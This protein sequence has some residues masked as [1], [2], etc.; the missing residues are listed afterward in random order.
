MSPE[1]TLLITLATT[2]TILIGALLA[3]YKLVNPIWKK[4][5]LWTHTWE[6]FMQDWVGTPE[7]EGRGKV[8]GVMER[9]NRIDGQLTKN[10]GSSVKDAVD[11]IEVRIEKGDNKFISLEKRIAKLEKDAL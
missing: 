9:L 6:N 11:R 4:V 10:G 3:V 1:L 7:R 2:V 8:P 5:S